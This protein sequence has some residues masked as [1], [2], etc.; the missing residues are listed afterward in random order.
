VRAA[1]KAGDASAVTVQVRAGWYEL[2]SGLEFD[3]QDSGTADAPVG[4]AGVRERKAKRSLAATQSSNG[5]H[6]RTRILQTDV[7][8]QGFH[9]VAFKQLFFGGKRQILA[10]YPNYDPQNPYSGGWAYAD[11]EMWPMYADKD[12]EDRHTLLVKPQDWRKWERP[13]D[14]EVFVF[15]RYNWWNDILRVKNVDAE[16]HTVTTAKDGSYA[17]RANDRYYFQG[18]LEDLDA[19]GEWYLDRESWTLYFK[20]PAPI[21][22]APVL[23]PN[24]AR[25]SSPSTTRITSRYA[26]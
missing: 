11:G 24:H 4:V 2:S 23:R 15:P 13:Q 8:M 6:G 10:R 20:P 3:A 18:A 21:D 1:R 9:G 5:I 25:T 26:A 22:S 19:P 12:G 17:M 14:V 7:R 16:K